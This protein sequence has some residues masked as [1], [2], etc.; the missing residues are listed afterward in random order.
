[1]ETV[2]KLC[3]LGADIMAVCSRD[4]TALRWAAINGHVDCL[5]RLVDLARQT[6]AFDAKSAGL[7]RDSSA[8]NG[9]GTPV[10]ITARVQ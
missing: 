7:G 1:M 9:K 10:P 5:G 6:Q 4:R 2:E 8:N 3:A